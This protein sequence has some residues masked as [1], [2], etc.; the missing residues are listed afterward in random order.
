[1]PNYL[2]WAKVEQ[3]EDLSRKEQGEDAI[4]AFEQAAKLF[5]E[6]N[7]SLQTQLDKIENPDERQM[8]TGMVKA[9]GERREYC[10]GRIALEEAKILD[11]KGDHYSSSQKYGSAAE[12]FEKITD[13]LES[14]QDRKEFKLII[15]L[16]QAWQKMMLAEARAS[17][18]LYMEASQ[19][20]EQS[21]EHSS[22]E[23]TSFLTL[24]H[25]R[26]CKALEAGTKFADT[27][28]VTLHTVAQQHLE[29]AAKYYVKAGFQSASEYA[30]ATE[31]LLDAYVH[32]DNAKKEPDPEKKAR[33]YTMA[34]K[35]LQTSAGSFMK[36]EH[37]EK[38]EQVLR[39]L[40][41]VKEERELALSLSEV[42]HAPSIVSTTAAFVSPTPNQENA[43][44][45]ER[46]EHADI[47]ANIITRQKELKVGEN[48]N[49]EIELINA[50]KGPA[51]L[52]K[53]AEV[54]PEGFE[55][56][57]KPEIYRVE[58][59]YLNMKGKR[60]DPLKTEEV[61]LILKPKAQGVF[62]L[63]PMIHYLDENGKY[64]SH[65]PE[66]ITITVK[67]LGIKGWLK[68]ER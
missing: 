61:R 26:F 10:L 27:G 55:L 7:K 48:L 9:T 13:R 59:S 35:V 47:Q 29:S 41:K 62:S 23:K 63:K 45:L 28:D 38:R 31:L 14:E 52:I 57:E 12:I 64:K 68:G 51:L 56:T 24:G 17:P 25:S 8:A 6:T 3:A 22:S 50:G 18:E 65:E 4:Q 19:L 46:F 66:P 2:A 49:L 15:T 36:A 42:L 11:K 16:S 44:G 53:L 34:E 43:V 5:N 32:M 60:L 21:S 67:E 1:M 20:F 39:L 33:L 54:I 58:D 30:K 40:E 37:P